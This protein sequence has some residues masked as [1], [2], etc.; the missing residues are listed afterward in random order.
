MKICILAA[1]D[2][3]M[4]THEDKLYKPVENEA[5]ICNTLL[6]IGNKAIIGRIVEQ[7][8]RN[9]EFVIA[10]VSYDQQTKDYLKIA[11]PELKVTF[12]QVASFNEP[13]PSIDVSLYSCKEKLLEPFIF[14]DCNI[15]TLS[16]LPYV[17][18]NW[19]G[20][21]KAD[22][23]KNWYSVELNDSGNVTFI[24]KK[25]THINTNL[26]SIGIAYIKDYLAFW[27]GFENGMY[28]KLQVINGLRTLIPKGLKAIFMDLKYIN[29]VQ[30][31]EEAILLYEKNY[32]FSG[33]ITDVTY[34]HGNKIIKFFEN[35]AI[36]KM[37]YERAKK[38]NG[39]FA[40]VLQ[41]QGNFY[42]YTF[43][44]GKQLSRIINFVECYKFLCWVEQYLWRDVSIDEEK[45]FEV[46]YDFYY[47]K[48]L[49]R[50]N[51]FCHKYLLGGEENDE[52]FINDLRC[53]KVA[54]LLNQIDPTFFRIGIP[55]TYHGDLH[56]DNI[57]KTKTGYVLIDWRESF[58]SSIDIGDRYYDLAKFLHVLELNVDVMDRYRYSLKVDAKNYC[59]NHDCD[60][61]SLEAL[62]AFW[63]F[64]IDR[65]YSRNRI[66]ILNALVYINM[67]PLYAREMG[68]Y[69]YYLGRYSLQKALTIKNRLTMLPLEE[70]TD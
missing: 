42:S 14:T 15:L 23:I 63:R 58:G 37:R 1:R 68:T 67:A 56:L 69:L 29:D 46:S 26:V 18:T 64:V 55:S 8:N 6:P 38:Y 41:L 24:N 70:F 60:Y 61:R 4:G 36:S 22:N 52:L 31:Y 5:M 66:R 28:G 40:N 49:Q 62:E 44:D 53:D 57:I 35:P 50:L 30:S 27:N 19:I 12:V 32:S 13:V 43:Q 25:P 51:L 10:M 54:N 47:N 2:N 3:Q 45:F 65:G 48:T 9:S 17:N 16:P 33:K 59:I 21:Q 34:R 7:F 20:I 39:I 11:Y